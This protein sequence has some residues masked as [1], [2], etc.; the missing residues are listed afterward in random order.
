MKYLVSAEA[1]DLDAKVHKR[2][3]GATYHLVI[4]SET[5]EY[6]VLTGKAE[7]E[8]SHGISRF[9]NLGVEYVLTGNVGPHAFE[10]FTSAGIS[11]F[12]CRAMTVRE[13]VEKVKSGSIPKLDSPTMKV[14]VHDAR[15]G[16]TGLGRGR[17]GGRHNGGR[18]GR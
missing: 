13:A 6:I 1:P 14:S 10:D 18:G 7:D 5:M 15:K 17:G 16:R 12:P 8:Q 2:F 4:D 9:A 11:V 3:G